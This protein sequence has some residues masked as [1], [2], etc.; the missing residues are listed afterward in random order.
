MAIPSK[1][2]KYE[3]IEEIGLGGMA[4]VYKG[5]HPFFNKYIAIKVLPSS[6]G[7]DKE[8]VE[9]FTREAKTMLSLQHP[10]IVRIYDA[11]IYED[12]YFIV[13]D[14]IEGKTVKELIAEKSK[15]NKLIDIDTTINIIMQVADALSYAH[16]HNVIHRDIKP[17]NILYEENK[18]TAYVAD[19][20]IAK[21][22]LET[23][24]TQTG[25]S[26]GTPEYMSPEQFSGAT[27]VDNRTDIYSLGIVFYEMLTG[28]LPFKG[29]TPLGVAFKQVNSLP[30]K[31][32]IKNPKISIYL[33]KVL[34]KM[35]EKDPSDRY[36]SM[37]ELLTDLKYFQNKEYQKMLASSYVEEK[38]CKLSINSHPENAKV[39]IDGEYTGL[40]P[41][42]GIDVTYGKHK[43]F[44]ILSGYEVITD[45]IDIPLREKIYELSFDLKPEIEKDI[46][47]D[48]AKT[49]EETKPVQNIKVSEEAQKQMSTAN[50]DN[51]SLEEL[52]KRL[53]KEKSYTESRTVLIKPEKELKIPIKKETIGP[54]TKERIKSFLLKPSFLIPIIAFILIISLLFVFGKGRNQN[55]ASFSVKS[56]PQGC[57]VYVDG[58]NIGLTPLNEYT[59]KAGNHSI[60]LLKE[61]YDDLEDTI[62]ITKNEKKTLSYTLKKETTSPTTTTVEIPVSIK[63][64]PT[65]AEVYID[66]SNKSIGAT[67]IENYKLSEGNHTIILKKEGYEDKTDTIE[68]KKGE[69]ISKEYTLVVKKVAIE[70]PISIKSNPAEA[71]VYIGDKQ[72]GVTPIENY[73]LKVGTYS[74]K[75][76][77]EGY[78]DYTQTLTISSSDTSKSILANLTKKTAPEIKTGTLSINS[79]PTGA[80]VYINKT[81]KGVTPI[82]VKL[83][84]GTCNL[85]L[86][87][88]GYLNYSKTI[89]IKANQ[90]YSLNQT[91]KKIEKT[92]IVHIYTVPSGATIYIDYVKVGT[93]PLYF[94]KIEPGYHEIRVVKEGYLDYCSEFNVNDGETKSLP[95]ITLIK[96]P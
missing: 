46:L 8:F 68:V 87:K 6:L 27:Q 39:Y 25:V 21:A 94:F 58:K 67:P 57:E 75:I 74:L 1:I 37:E 62:S 76:K 48:A 65:G 82:T 61:G 50:S 54:F 41:L 35:L 77:K 51:L 24:L 96:L 16:K 42:Q 5:V 63:S 44:I 18:K 22:V 95:Q 33:E 45:E 3:V 10:H 36:Q 56:E 23:K 2:D 15:S 81:Y 73:K 70:I 11:G 92:A 26:L 66:N 12:N 53:K 91:L 32:R 34:L 64:N 19:F 90:K 29:D 28:D 69:E 72:I 60:K 84:V 83:N 20:G 43:V 55:I 49:E 88:D 86:I 79:N 4:V 7:Q 40:T 13:M 9:R 52:T 78:N 14:F 17:S 80:K 31:P 30:T 47:T 38:R 93:S 89:E 85:S 59:I 71:Q